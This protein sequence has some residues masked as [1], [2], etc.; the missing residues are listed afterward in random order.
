MRGRQ[1]GRAGE[2]TRTRVDRRFLSCNSLSFGPSAH[3]TDQ[4]IAEILE[5]G[6]RKAQDS[7][8]ML[9]AANGR[10]QPRRPSANRS[11][12]SRRLIASSCQTSGTP[13]SGSKWATKCGMPKSNAETAGSKSTIGLAARRSQSGWCG[14]KVS[15][16]ARVPVAVGFAR[17]L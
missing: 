14:Q 9:E 10:P 16:L 15:M 5:L 4:F 6:Q 7:L 11:F 13:H 2:P 3:Q 12:S 17:T 1:T 8:G